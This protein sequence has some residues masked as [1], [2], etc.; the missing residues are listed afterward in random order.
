MNKNITHTRTH[1]HMNIIQP[2]K[3]GN[4]TISLGKGKMYEGGQN[5]Q[6]FSYKINK[7]YGYNV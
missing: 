6:T 1:T 7:S 2:W 4:P 3:V 5:L